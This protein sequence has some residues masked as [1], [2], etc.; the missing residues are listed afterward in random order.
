MVS[1][2]Y[3][4]DP[5]LAHYGIMGMK[6]GIRRYQNE[7]GSLT[8]EGRARYGTV[9]SLEAARRLKRGGTFGVVGTSVTGARMKKDG[10]I[11]NLRDNFRG[12]SRKERE[13]MIRNEQKKEREQM[14]RNEQ[15]KEREAKWNEAKKKYEEK[16][17][18]FAEFYGDP[19][20]GKY[21]SIRDDDNVFNY[22]HK[23]MLREDHDGS[24]RKK[25]VD[26]G[27]F[28]AVKADREYL[29]K[30]SFED[31]SIQDFSQQDY[32]DWWGDVSRSNTI[33]W[34]EI[35]WNRTRRR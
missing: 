16:K 12:K 15:K 29:K 25:Y 7:D 18:N 33:S 6:W 26:S 24:Y 30:H 2:D 4:D 14:I 1:G 13:Q 28:D 20:E 17:K 22:V 27:Y 11:K 35:E 10:S 9:E 32:A 8:A 31:D 21:R 19:R 34:D 5:Y 3:W 23:K